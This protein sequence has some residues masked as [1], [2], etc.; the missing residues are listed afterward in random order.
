M[1]RKKITEI[2]FD[3]RAIKKNPIGEHLPCFTKDIPWEKDENIF[4][5]HIEEKIINAM[6]LKSGNHID[7]I[8]KKRQRKTKKRQ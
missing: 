3:G 5:P 8:V 1:A 6:G 2:R 4:V 7:I